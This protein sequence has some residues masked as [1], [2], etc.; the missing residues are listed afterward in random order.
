M[1]MA[2]RSSRSQRHLNYLAFQS[3]DLCFDNHHCSFCLF[4]FGLLRDAVFDYVFG[5]FSS[6]KTTTI[7]Y[8]Y[9]IF[10]PRFFQQCGKFA[11][12][13][14]FSIGFLNDFFRHCSICG[15]HLIIDTV[16]VNGINNGAVYVY[17]IPDDFR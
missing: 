15:L 8:V 3:F 16:T 14:D 10:L 9:W 13:W 4:S 6:E 7:Y 17:E 12:F 2:I 1:V 11:S 5:I